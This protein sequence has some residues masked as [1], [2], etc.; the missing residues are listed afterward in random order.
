MKY[1]NWVTPS[2]KTIHEKESEDFKN[3]EEASLLN[4]N[5]IK[6]HNNMCAL[7]V[8]GDDVGMGE[9]WKN[10]T[11]T[12][13]KKFPDSE[14]D[15]DKA[16]YKYI[17]NMLI[18]S[19]NHYLVTT[20]MTV[21]ER[22]KAAEDVKEHLEMAQRGLDAL[23]IKV[24]GSWIAHYF[25]EAGQTA[26]QTNCHEKD[27]LSEIVIPSISRRLEP[28]QG[29]QISTV[30]NREK[31]VAASNLANG[32]Y[33]W[34]GARMLPTVAAL[35]STIFSD[36]AF[37]RKR[38]KNAAEDKEITTWGASGNEELKAALDHVSELFGDLGE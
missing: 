8:G 11:R 30:L 18:C 28:V 6:G 12:F 36:P 3:L 24:R 5:E 20:R 4:E 34:L 23:G 35:V 37:D 9:K 27:L 32:F 38:A 17:R 10:L 7:L 13:S 1:A 25:L 22:N 31:H 15:G 19:A 26:S 21:A 16:I 14:T 29:I 2:I 33:Y